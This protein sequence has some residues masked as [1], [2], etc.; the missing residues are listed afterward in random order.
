MPFAMQRLRQRVCLEKFPDQLTGCN[1][2]AGF[3]R[4]GLGQHDGRPRPG[5]AAVFDAVKHDFSARILWRFV[6]LRI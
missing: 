1:V 2:F 3:A 4:P 6:I 5:V